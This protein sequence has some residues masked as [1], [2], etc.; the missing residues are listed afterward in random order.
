MKRMVM[1]T[2]DEQVH[3]IERGRRKEKCK[4]LRQRYKLRHFV[5]PDKM[6][7]NA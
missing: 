6:Q 7:Y 5:L 2:Q 4:S 3:N 1:T